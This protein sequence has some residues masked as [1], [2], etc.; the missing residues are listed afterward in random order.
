MKLPYKVRSIV[1]DRGHTGGPNMAMVAHIP[2]IVRWIDIIL[3][4]GSIQNYTCW[5]WLYMDITS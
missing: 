1:V 3:D 5:T 2:L 4:I